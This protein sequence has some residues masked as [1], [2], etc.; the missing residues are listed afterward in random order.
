MGLESL[1]PNAVQTPDRQA[2]CLGLDLLNHVAG[3]LHLKCD[4]THAENQISSF[5]EMD[6]S[7]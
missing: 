7:I 5:G 6:E 2:T 4:G 1:A 3:R